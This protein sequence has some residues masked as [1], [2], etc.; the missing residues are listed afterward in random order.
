MKALVICGSSIADVVFATPIF[1]ALKVQLD[2]LELHILAHLASAFILEENPYVDRVHCSQQSIWKNYQRLKHEKFEI[3]IN[4]A[5]DVL[6]R[7]LAFILPGTNYALKSIR[8]K[9]WLMVNLKIEQLPTRHLVERMFEGLRDLG[10]KPDEL[11]LD[12]FIP[13]K[14]KVA[15]EWL[16][17]PFHKGYIVFCIG[18]AHNTRKLPEDRM[19]ELCDKINKPIVLLG[20]KD[21]ANTG[22][23]ISQFFNQ[24]AGDYERGL[25]ELNKRTII[26]NAC[27]KFNFNQMASIVKRARAIFTFDNDF[28]PVASAFKKE[29]FGLWGNTILLF[30]KYPYRTKFTVL[31]N[32]KIACRPCA[33]GGYSKCPKG[34]FNCMNQIV[35]DFYL[36]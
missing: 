6:S 20:S 31:E 25:L 4:L 5:E 11:G 9:Q 33:V 28:I 27:G 26:Y 13:D 35:F 18:A 17:E 21:D 3:I 10:A 36:G 22:N 32:N 8:W 29:I 19:I 12:Y 24:H 30:G 34:H 15:V 2:D 14:D 23:L 7:Y 16:P 1:R